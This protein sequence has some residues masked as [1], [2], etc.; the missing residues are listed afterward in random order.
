MKIIPRN[1]R[2]NWL[3]ATK[4]AGF[5]LIEVLV[6]LTILAILA[7]FIL[8]TTSHFRARAHESHCLNNLRTIGATLFIYAGDHNHEIGLLTYESAGTSV[9]W[10]N[11][12]RGEVYNHSRL[13]SSSPRGPNYIDDISVSVCP[14]FTPFINPLPG[15][16]A[17]H[18]RIY[19]AL[20]RTGFES[21]PAIFVPEGKAPYSKILRLNAVDLPSEHILLGDSLHAANQWQIYL[22][23]ANAAN[24]GVHL[25]H[26][27]K[28]NVLFASGHVETAS[29]ERLK[30]L[31]ETPISRGY[32]D[33]QKRINF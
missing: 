19:G 23:N 13:T 17:A 6:A 12:L 9:H 15:T 8:Q 3:W 18:N 4:P 21:N 22:M 10:L 25:R 26:R 29:P 32:N 20:S 33:Q 31:R 24:Y 1:P 5:S 11:Y 14:A 2:Q 27:G 30:T 7:L 16:T 28:A